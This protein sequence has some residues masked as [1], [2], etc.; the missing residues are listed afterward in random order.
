VVI[1]LTMKYPTY[2][3]GNSSIESCKVVFDNF[4]VISWTER[5]LEACF[6]FFLSDV[7]RCGYECCTHDCD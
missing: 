7:M 5:P 3:I 4:S 2:D 6:G 1:D